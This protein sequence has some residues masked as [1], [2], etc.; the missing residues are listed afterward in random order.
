[1]F[2]PVDHSLLDDQPASPSSFGLFTSIEEL[3]DFIDRNDLM[4]QPDQTKLMIEDEMIIQ[5]FR[6][7]QYPEFF[8]TNLDG[9]NYPKNY[10]DSSIASGQESYSENINSEL[11]HEHDD[12]ISF[13][14]T[15]WTIRDTI[16]RKIRPPKLHEFLRLLLDNERYVSY[17]SWL[18]KNAGLFK[19]HKPA[20]V[21]SLWRQVKIR[22]PVGSL[23]YD[24]FA[25]SIRYYYKSG[26]M[27]RT[28][29]KRTY[30]F[31]QV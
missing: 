29:T 7:E 27:I 15:Q 4:E 11:S 16:A 31:A 22:K 2:T 1:M 28:H 3:Y 26:L 21:A 20:Q 13:D 17:A 6:Y 19:I 25:R 18:D 12:E 30:R 5:N 14:A 8:P 9:T 23:D 24:I 10:N